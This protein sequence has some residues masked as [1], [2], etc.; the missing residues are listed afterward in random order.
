MPKPK[1]EINCVCTWPKMQW[2][3]F[4]NISICW[5]YEDILQNLTQGYLFF[6]KRF[7]MFWS[8]LCESYC[9]FKFFEPSFILVKNNINK[10]KL[11]FFI[12]CLWRAVQLLNIQYNLFQLTLTLVCNGSCGC[13]ILAPIQ[14]QLYNYSLLKGLGSET[15][16]NN[17]IQILTNLIPENLVVL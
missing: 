2:A 8:L 13:K 9:F 12:L 4:S 7:R 11:W 6:C 16:P 14:Y 10:R 5:H 17:L 1:V 3:A 15:G